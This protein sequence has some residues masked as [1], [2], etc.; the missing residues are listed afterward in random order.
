MER[1]DKEALKKLSIDKTVEL[2][3]VNIIDETLYESRWFTTSRGENNKQSRNRSILYQGA[4]GETIEE[5]YAYFAYPG[6]THYC[7]GNPIF[8]RDE[9]TRR[10]DNGSRIGILSRHPIAYFKIK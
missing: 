5:A 1:I 9:A 7:P 10:G 2:L 4:K 3:G 8:E 6:T